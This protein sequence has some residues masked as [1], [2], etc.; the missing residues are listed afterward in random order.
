VYTGL[1]E[2]FIKDFFVFQLLDQFG[3]HLV[4]AGADGRFDCGLD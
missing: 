2:E 1:V 4:N 3:S